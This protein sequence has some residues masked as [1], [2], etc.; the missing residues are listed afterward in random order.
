MLILSL[1]A[2]AATTTGP[3]D[4]PRSQWMLN[5]THQG[6]SVDAAAWPALNTTEQGRLHRKALAW[7]AHA[8][9]KGT[10]GHI[11]WGQAMPL[12]VFNNSER[13]VPLRYDDV[14]DTAAWTG[15]LLAGIIHKYALDG[16]AGTLAVAA[17][18][19]QS[20]NISTTC[21]EIGSFCGHQIETNLMVIR[22]YHQ[23]MSRGAGLVLMAPAKLWAPLGLLS[24]IT[25]FP[26]VLYVIIMLIYFSDYLAT[27]DFIIISK[28]QSPLSTPATVSTPA[29][30]MQTWCGR[31]TR[32]GT[33]MCVIFLFLSYVSQRHL[34]GLP[35]RS[36][37]CHTCAEEYS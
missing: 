15:T 33:H 34:H 7:Y 11:Q 32:A 13:T 9:Q 1:F 26:V 25:S 8:A 21:T 22:C 10:G 2:T 37:V 14:G 20:F 31:A 6:A 35:I 19:L 27:L 12:A 28:R 24:V 4:D 18:I 23:F 5:L 29:P 36:W 17:D 16:D 30:R 3:Y